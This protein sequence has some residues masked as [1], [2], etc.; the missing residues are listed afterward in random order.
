MVKGITKIY[1]RV[2][3]KGFN[4]KFC[5]VSRIQHETP[6][7]GLQTYRPERCEYNSE[8]GDNTSN[9]PSDR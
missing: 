1:P 8:D 9:I 6:E 5:V 4:S 3:N 2:L 7:V